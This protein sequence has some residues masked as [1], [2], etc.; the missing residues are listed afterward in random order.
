MIEFLICNM[1]CCKVIDLWF[2]NSSVKYISMVYYIVIGIKING[3]CVCSVFIEICRMRFYL[4]V[5]IKLVFF[6]KIMD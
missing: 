5:I 6:F 1:V 2:V 4:V 3:L